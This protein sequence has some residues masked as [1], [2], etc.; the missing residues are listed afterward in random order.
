[1][2]LRS[3]LGRVRGL[4]SAGSGTEHWWGQRVSAAALAVLLVWI[5]IALLGLPAL[6]YYSVHAWLARPLNAVLVILL[7]LSIAW[8]AKLGVEVVLQDYVHEKG[9]LAVLLG[10]SSILHLALA[11]AGVFAVALVAVGASA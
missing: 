9:L 10:L 8:H 11:I 3:P 6:D 5:V 1:M 4:G 7:L 2:S